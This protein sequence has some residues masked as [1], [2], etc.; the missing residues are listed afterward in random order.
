MA[1]EPYQTATAGDFLQEVFYEES[2][3]RVRVTNLVTKRSLEE[4]VPV[5]WRPVFGID[6][7]DAA[8]IDEVSERM[9]RELE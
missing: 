2:D 5:G 3:W 1:S 6:I 4:L 7:E 8:H 9:A